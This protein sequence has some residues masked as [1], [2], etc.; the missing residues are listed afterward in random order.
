LASLTSG[1]IGV[2]VSSLV[3]AQAMD[4]WG[5]RIPFLF[6]AAALPVALIMRRNFPETH[7][8]QKQPSF[9]ET[10]TMLGAYR[11]NIALGFLMIAGTTIPFYSL[12]Y[13]TT[14]AQNSLHM[15]TTIALAA[16]VVF[17]FS[18][19][20]A[21]LIGGSLSDRIGRRPVLIWT[22]LVLIAIV[23]PA[24]F[25]V[26]HFPSAG[27]LLGVTALLA[28][29]NFL[30]GSVTITVVSECVPKAIRGLA[31]GGAYATAV[32]MFG[33]T[34]QLAIA[35]LIGATGNKLAPAIYLAAASVVA[36][37]AYVLIPETSERFAR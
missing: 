37:I 28:V 18:N 30:S 1:V 14:F 26:V 9:E 25:A 16:T 15:G 2:A 34:T 6:G 7:S 19:F 3:S 13:M 4:L 21:S 22:R 5:W 20:A 35:W 33:G 10:R 31:S 8:V 24:Y 36:V 32:A 12:S 29:T 11:R 23:Y 17:G 27:M